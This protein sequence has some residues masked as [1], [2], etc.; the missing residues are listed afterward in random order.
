MALQYK[1]WRAV[2]ELLNI[3]NNQL[4][5]FKKIKKTGNRL[6]RKFIVLEGLDGSGDEMNTHYSVL[7]TELFSQENQPLRKF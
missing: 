6:N 3:Y 2:Q 5:R 1:N 7:L 4:Y